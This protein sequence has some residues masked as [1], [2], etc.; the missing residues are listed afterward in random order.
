MSLNKNNFLLFFLFFSWSIIFSQV[1][2]TDST[3]LE[4]VK[5]VVVTVQFNLTTIR[6]WM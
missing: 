4:Q 5:E 2:E 3:A 6:K 1:L